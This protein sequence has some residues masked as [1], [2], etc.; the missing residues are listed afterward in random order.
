MYDLIVVGGGAV[1]LYLAAEFQK[2]GNSVLVLER[3]KEI[4]EKVCSGLVSRNILK[5]LNLNQNQIKNI[6]FFEKRFLQTRIWIEKSSFNFDGEAYLFNRQKF[7]EYLFLK[8]KELGVEIKLGNEVKEIKER[9]GFVEAETEEGIFKG[10]I[11]AGCDGAASTVARKSGLPEQKKVLLGVVAYLRQEASG[12]KC[13]KDNFPELF[14]SKKFPGFFLWRLP[15]KNCIECGIALEPKYKP[16]EVLE[17]WLETNRQQATPKE[18]DYSDPTGQAGSRRL[19]EDDLHFQCA[20]IPFFP[21]KKTAAKRI[22]LCG[23]AA[24]QIKSYTGGGLVYGFICAKIAAEIIN[25]QNPDLSLYEKKWRR[26]LMKEIRLG[27]L[28]RKCY[29]LPNFVKKAGLSF[30]TKLKEID[31]DKPSTIFKI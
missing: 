10:K 30:L 12:L 16:K 13:N 1:G 26:E 27:N 4:G 24:G 18:S 20:L 21:L 9:G 14:F 11:L 25:P 31:Q 2:K 22:F 6:D 19:R 23:D 17:K 5:L 3:K 7:D 28:I 29:R 15:H 8:A